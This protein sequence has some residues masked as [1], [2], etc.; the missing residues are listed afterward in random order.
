MI[1]Q[2]ELVEGWKGEFCNRME[3]PQAAKVRTQGPISHEQSLRPPNSPTTLLWL[4]RVARLEVKGIGEV[5][6]PH[7]DCNHTAALGKLRGD[8]PMFSS[9]EDGALGS[10]GATS[11]E[12]GGTTRY[13]RAPCLF[14]HVPVV[15]TPASSA[16]SSSAALERHAWSR[17]SRLRIA[18]HNSPRILEIWG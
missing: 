7:F 1:G 15:C 11:H 5:D 10:A 2:L 18:S 13:T 16:E 3:D 14:P 17:P 9:L 6:G 4:L 12:G 8:W